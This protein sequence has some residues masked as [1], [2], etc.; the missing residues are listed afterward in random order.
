MA[1]GATSRGRGGGHVDDRGAYLPTPEEIAAEAARLRAKH[2]QAKL[3]EASPNDPPPGR[4]A[5]LAPVRTTGLLDAL[6]S[7]RIRIST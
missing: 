5:T 4:L 3:A 2:L 6:R 1:R 7:S